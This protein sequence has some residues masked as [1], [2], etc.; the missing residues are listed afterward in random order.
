MVKEFT[1]QLSQNS[2]VAGSTIRGSVVVNNNEPKSYKKI[3]VYLK[4]HGEVKWTETETRSTG[5]GS[6]ST[7]SSSTR[8]YRSEES[9]VHLECVVWS[10]S[11]GVLPAGRHTFPFQ[12]TI[13]GNC[14]SSFSDR[15]GKIE[16]TI[17]GKIVSKNFLKKNHVIR[18]LINVLGFVDTRT[19]FAQDPVQFAKEKQLGILCFPRGT[20][21]YSVKLPHSLF[22]VGEHIQ[23]QIRVDNESGRRVR[24]KVSLIE[25]INYITPRKQRHSK[26]VIMAQQSTSL[27]PHR[28]SYWDSENFL[29]PVIRPAITGSNIIKSAYFLHVV[30]RIPWSCNSSMTIPVVIGNTRDN[31]QITAH[32]AT[33]SA[34]A[35]T[36]DRSPPVFTHTATRGAHAATI[37]RNPTGFANTETL[38]H[39][40]GFFTHFANV[41]RNPPATLDCNNP[42]FVPPPLFP[43]TA[44]LDRNPPV[45]AQPTAPPL[46]TMTLDRNPPVFAQ[47]T[48]SPLP[49]HAATLDRNPPDFAH[50]DSSQPPSYWECVR[51]DK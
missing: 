31:P 33:R 26:S 49:P 14:P 24:T 25:R 45:F 10:N 9:Y 39:N 34:P 22:C 47:P 7:S 12:F 51:N 50:R 48:A 32:T 15:I 4:G 2:F 37:D 35:A 29:V 8:T 21:N 23:T 36:V 6:H 38:D 11:D 40:P 41:D 5:S 13:P 46:H 43:G 27:Q 17:S 18:Y 3:V 42:V 19:R 28:T 20:I 44:T 1:I 16:Y 30:I